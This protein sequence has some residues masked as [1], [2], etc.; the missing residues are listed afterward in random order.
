MADT[1]HPL[2]S[3]TA[4]LIDV[5]RAQT[6]RLETIVEQGLARTLRTGSGAATVAYRQRALEQA[7]AQLAALTDATREATPSIV[8][9]GYT[10]TLLTVDKFAGDTA[11]TAGARATFGGV[12]VAATEAL[13]GQMSEALTAAIEQTGQR[14]EDVFAAANAIEG[15]LDGSGLVR[16]IPFLG[17]RFNDQLRELSLQAVAGATVAGDTRRQV[18]RQLAEQLIR[19]GV[20]A[21]SAGLIDTGGRRW[22]LDHYAAMVARTTTRE[23]MTAATANRMTE[24]GLDLVAISSHPHKADPCSPF[25]GKTF[26]LSGTSTRYPRLEQRPPFHPF[27]RH[28]ILPAGANLDEFEADLQGRVLPPEPEPAPPPRS[29]APPTTKP[30]RDRPQIV[31][32]EDAPAFHKLQETGAQIRD[33]AN[34]LAGE[35][36]ETLTQEILRQIAERKAKE[37]AGADPLTLVADEIRTEQLIANLADVEREALLDALK[38]A[39]PG[40]GEGV[41]EAAGANAHQTEAL[42]R[43]AEMLPREWVELSNSH[44]QPLKIKTRKARAHYNP[45]LGEMQL[46]PDEQHSVVLHELI[47]RM[48]Q[49]VPGV[50]VRER[51][52][53]LDR[54]TRPNGKLA[55]KRKLGDLPGG[56]GYSASEVYRGAWTEPYIGRDYA[57]KLVGNAYATSR[58]VE[59]KVSGLPDPVSPDEISSMA[60]EG[61]FYGRHGIT[62]PSTESMGLKSWAQKNVDGLT[63]VASE[64]KLRASEAESLETFERMI[65]LI[66]NGDKELADLF[67]GI[68]ATL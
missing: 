31:D 17:R 2:D 1:P 39:R 47:H 58:G 46:R 13:A 36:S 40:F 33:R 26:S 6:R 8:G 28:V 19:E 29:P 9:R 30:V 51:D 3:L 27:C 43:A 12:H 37:A 5:Y 50:S 35:R 38:E 22:A 24:T 54:I 53:Y 32:P 4:S 15:A 52:F 57:R 23:V 20:A 42:K 62:K 61:V 64:R 48:Q 66:D 68:L 59:S 21:A 7:R 18:S 14:V 11:L 56:Y 63:E 44:P 55:R 41:V 25:D 10:A 65:D 60:A 16:E 49:V 67:V 34:R 45:G